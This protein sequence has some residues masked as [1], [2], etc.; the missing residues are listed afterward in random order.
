M[1]ITTPNP[2]TRP[3]VYPLVDFTRLVLERRDLNA[4][5]AGTILMTAFAEVEGVN[6]GSGVVATIRIADVQTAAAA[7]AAAGKPA[8][9]NALLAFKAAAEELAREQGLFGLCLL[10]T[11]R[12]G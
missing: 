6:V 1:A 12:R 9:A 2:V 3:A 5:V 10:Y 7:R 11:S 4:P 8:L